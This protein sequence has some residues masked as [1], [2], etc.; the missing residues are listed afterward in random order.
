MWLAHS[1]SPR[2]ISW[3]D[4]HRIHERDQKLQACLRKAPKLS[5]KCLHPGN[6]KQNTSLA[7]GIFHE[8]TIA[9]CRS[10][11]PEKNYAANFLNL[12]LTWWTISN[13]N[14]KYNPNVLG[15]AITKGDGKLC[16]L[17]NLPTG[18]KNGLDVPIFSQQ[19]DIKSFDFNA[20]ITSHADRWTSQWRLW[21]RLNASTSQ[22]IF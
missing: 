15:N 10:Y 18:W 4:L 20:E 13:S 22:S 19:T 8:T 17:R 11:F 7:L 12:I 16:F 14:N 1:S 5:H 2:D 3:H 9:A 6:D 21:L